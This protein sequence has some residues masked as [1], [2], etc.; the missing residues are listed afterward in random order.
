MSR[1]DNSAHKVNHHHTI[2]TSAKNQVIVI[3][4]PRE[5]NH[6]QLVK[7]IDELTIAVSDTRRTYYSSNAIIERVQSRDL[8]DIIGARLNQISARVLAGKIKSNM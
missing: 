6:E 1:E 4:G 5:I 7:M 2:D 8:R 3:D